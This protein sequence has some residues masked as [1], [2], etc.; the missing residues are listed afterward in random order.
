MGSAR[1]SQVAREKAADVDR[2]FSMEHK[3]RELQRKQE[4]YEAQLV[5]LKGQYETE[6]DAILRELEEEKQRQRVVA[7]HRLEI[8]RLR[9]ADNGEV[10]VDTNGAKKS[11]K[12]P[13]R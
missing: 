11:R 7:N 9:Q 6:R 13:G 4:L 5:A 8:A 12:G 2:K 1:S 3:Q 10:Q